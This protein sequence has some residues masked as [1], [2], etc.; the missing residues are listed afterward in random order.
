MDSLILL[1]SNLHCPSCVS[2]V[3][4][5][6]SHLPGIESA[7][8]VSLITQTIRVVH[9]NTVISPH[10]IIE[11][12]VKSALEIKHVVHLNSQGHQVADYDVSD[13]NTLTTGGERPQKSHIDS[14][15]AC[16][17][18]W[19]GKD[20]SVNATS[21]TAT[22][23][24]VDVNPN[25]IN[26]QDPSQDDRYN[27]SISIEGMSCGSCTGKVMRSLDRLPF[28]SKASVDLLSHMGVVEYFER[29]NLDIILHQIEALGYKATPIQV[30]EPKP[31]PKRDVTYVA[32]LSIEGMSCGSCTGKI[33]KGLEDLNFVTEIEVDLLNNSG[34][35]SFTGDESNVSKVL[36]KVSDIGYKATLVELTRP[37]ALV[38]PEERVIDFS[39]QGMHCE[40]CP[41]RIVDALNESYRGKDLPRFR[42]TRNP[43]MKEPHLQITYTPS[44]PEGLSLRRFISIVEAIDQAFSVH[45]KHPPTIEERSRRIQRQELQAIVVRMIFVGIVTIPSLILGVVYMSLVPKHNPTRMWFEEPIW[46]GSAMRIDWALFIMTTPVMFFGTDI[47][48]RRAFKEI[49]AMW[50]PGSTVPLLRRFYRFGSMNLLISVGTSVAY[51]SSLAVLAMNAARKSREDGSMRM[52]SSYFDVVTFL[53]F[54]ILIGRFLEAYSK[55]KTG[56]T[57]ARLAKLRPNEALLVEED[58]SITKIPV[59]QL[60]LGDVVQVPQGHSP[61]ADGLVK[62]EGSFSFDESSLTG[63]S[64]PVRKAK[65]DVVF[66]GTVNVADPVEIVVT[67]LG[68]TSMLDQII[69]AVRRGQAK[70]API[71]RIADVLTGYFVPVVTLLA[72]VTW[73]TWLGLGVSGRLP[74]AWLDVPEG[75]WPFWSLEFAIAVFVVACP[76]GIG[77]AAPTALFVG[78]GLAAKKGVLV[79]GGGQAFQE[80]SNLDVIVFDK[81]G[82]LTQGQMKVTDFD[83]LQEDI[84]QDRLFLMAMA[85]EGLSSHPIAQAIV[86]YCGSK[87]NQMAMTDVQELP[88]YGMTGKFTFSENSKE[89]IVEAAIGNAQLLDFL[90][91]KDEPT[92]KEDENILSS[93]TRLQEALRHHQSQGHS[94]AIIAVRRSSFYE[95]A[96]IF[97]LSDPIRPEAPKV[98]AALRNLGLSVHLCTGDNDVTAHAIAAQLDI[99][100]ENVRAGVLPQGKSEYINQLQH[101]AGGRRRLVAFTGDGLNDTPALTAADVSISMSSGSD[102]AMNASSFILVNSHLEAIYD[103]L[104][105]SRRVFFR[106]KLNFFWAAIYNITLIP[107]AAGVLYMIGASDTHPGWR[108]SPVWASVAMAGSS[109]SVILSSLALKLPELRWPSRKKS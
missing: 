29:Q 44:L 41:E 18:V 54:F 22:V 108:M 86:T 65:G 11:A 77:L 4:D 49:W 42:I 66:T 59:D 69:E 14:C 55:A 36:Q 81:T 10:E 2:H 9:D 8:E 73:V 67:G 60:E 15:E 26:I 20:F 53:T 57:V 37:A 98:I 72:I 94:T 96:G 84:P 83:Q 80:A 3:Q 27:A 106:V 45:V 16:Q 101:P 95:A 70:R 97:A 63:E 39:I 52:S 82:T 64:K 47:F 48:H 46:V 25:I 99:P 28:V 6:L 87:L 88:G 76:C 12:L 104:T 85:M 21:S 68:G 5:V 78:G 89:R 91:K 56:D 74:D 40:Q 79:Q 71:E 50:K 109:V 19:Q 92:A 7:S 62:Q 102:I 105:V 90:N 13:A 24:K 1:V 32:S 75:G 31:K 38:A 58:Q 51:V 100:V 103:L 23:T 33:R 107:V 35:V 43:T 93:H 30:I 34:S 17:K 61:P